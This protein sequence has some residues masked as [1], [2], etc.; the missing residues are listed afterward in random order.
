[1]GFCKFISNCTI[2][3]CLT[4]STFPKRQKVVISNLVMIK[5]YIGITCG[6]LPRCEYPTA[7]PINLSFEKNDSRLIARVGEVSDILLLQSRRQRLS[8]F[9]DLHWIIHG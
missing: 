5:F 2:Y 1:M 7:T 8:D 9:F 4:Q 3:T 6:L